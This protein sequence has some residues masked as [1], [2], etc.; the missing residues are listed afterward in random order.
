M[1]R[2][3]AARRILVVVPKLTVGGTERHLLAILPRLDRARFRVEV[4][5]TRGA[6]PLDQALRDQGIPV[7]PAP[8]LFSGHINALVALPWLWWRLVRQRPDMLHLLLP[9]AYLVGGLAALLAAFRRCVMSRR[10]LNV[11]QNKRPISRRLEHLL[12][13]Y[14]AALVGNSR[15]AVEQLASEG[16]PRERLTLIHNGIDMAAFAKGDRTAARSALGLAPDSLVLLIVA[17]LLPYKG[18]AD[19]LQALAGI[20][21]QLPEHWDLLIAGRDEG[22]GAGLRA[23]AESAGLANHLHWLGERGDVAALFAASDIAVL[24]SHE[25]SF[26]NAALEAMAAGL[27]VIATQVGGCAEAVED[28]VTGRLVPPH[29]PNALGQAILALARDREVRAALGRAGRQR[30]AERFSL[31]A[32]V[33]AYEGLYDAVLAGRPLAAPRDAPAIVANRQ[34]T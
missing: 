34:R 6:G 23:R 2:P 16:A 25:E 21:A 32:C 15:A 7:T 11:Y 30:V 33:A 22:I 9:E 18:H 31:E 24:A 12:H 17:T 8:A 5:T 26:P 13:R 29:Y 14:M 27:P 19:L 20:P 10:S 4:M 28:G 3:P 1:Q